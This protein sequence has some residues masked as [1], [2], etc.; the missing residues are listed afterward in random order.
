M[1][2]LHSVVLRGR[3]RDLEHPA[4]AQ[5]DV[6]AERLDRADRALGGAGEDERRVVAEA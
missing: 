2:L 4:A 3:R 6:L 5:P 1:A